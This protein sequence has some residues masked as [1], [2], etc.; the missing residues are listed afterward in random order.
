MKHTFNKTNKHNKKS[1][2][3]CISD[4]K[5][6]NLFPSPFWECE[7]NIDN[8]K[9]VQE[10]YH[11]KN[12]N[13]EGGIHSNI[14]GWQSEVFE[15]VPDIEKESPEIVNISKLIIEFVNKISCEYE[16]QI[17][18]NHSDI[19]WWIN[20]NNKFCYNVFHS[21]PS[22]DLIALYYPKIPK[23]IQSSQNSRDGELTI[24][25]SD[26]SIHNGF[27]SNVENFCEYSF[28]P[29][30]KH[31]Y[32]MPSTLGHYV[33]PQFSDQDRISIAFNIG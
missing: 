11:F 10:C 27:F 7:L 33:T 25:R 15:I 2:E 24:L 9:V 12:I 3:T 21:H 1:I 13:P 20:I 26:P 14:N 17:V 8:H 5:Y 30:E 32:L 31:L 18:Y 22:C 16:C 28:F 23:E 19:G 6:K 4:V 29:K